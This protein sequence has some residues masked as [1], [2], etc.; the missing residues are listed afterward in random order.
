M[1]DCGHY[2][3]R[4]RGPIENDRAR[5]GPECGRL[6][7]IVRTRSIVLLLAATIVAA[8]SCRA[9]PAPGSTGRPNIVFVLTDDQRW[10]AISLEG[11][12]GP[13]KTPNIDRLGQE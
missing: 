5:G 11:H 8:W 4:A 1:S 10:D 2:S 7:R 12:S 9:A 3:Y 6:P 13:L